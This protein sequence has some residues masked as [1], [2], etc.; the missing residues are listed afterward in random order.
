MGGI[1]LQTAFNILV[2]LVGSMGGWILGRIT[3]TLDQLDKDVRAL[4]DKYVTKANYRDDMQDIKAALRR[5]EEKLD[6]KADK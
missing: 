1:D 4:P 3:K 2:L 5:I 6:G